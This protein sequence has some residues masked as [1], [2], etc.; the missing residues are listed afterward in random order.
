MANATEEKTVATASLEPKR[1]RSGIPGFDDLIGGGI[2][3]GSLVVVSGDPGSGKT[4]FCLGFLYHGAKDYGEP[5]VYLSL[6]ESEQEVVKEAAYYGYDF[7]SLIRQRLLL[8]TT[9]SLYDFDKLKNTIEEALESTH[10]KRLVIDPGVVFRL[11]FEKELEARKTIL[12]LGKML[13]RIK[14][15]AIITNE[16]SLDKINSLFGLE[17]FVADG[18]ILLYHTKLENRFIRSIGVLKM[19]G[20]R[21]SE[22]LHPIEITG[23]GIRVLSKQELFEEL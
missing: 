3:E 16:I 5:G 13:K 21:I 20:T 1:I 23:N 12:N 17:E 7:N 9:V 2:P 15:T 11:F 22:K 19:R 8:V 18:V 10:A 4:A 14:V 6:E